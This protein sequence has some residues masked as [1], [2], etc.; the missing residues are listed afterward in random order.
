ML[1]WLA[2]MQAS[3]IDDSEYEWTSV[4]LSNPK[5]DK[6]M[7]VVS[8]QSIDYRTGSTEYANDAIRM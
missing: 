5:S 8:G 2:V 4:R 7:V 6:R 3:Q 1:P